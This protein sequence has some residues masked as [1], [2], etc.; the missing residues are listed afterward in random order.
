MTSHHR[1]QLLSCLLME[2]SVRRA[3]HH[4]HIQEPA[5]CANALQPSIP[6]GWFA[7]K[8]SDTQDEQGAV[9]QHDVACMKDLASST[10]QH[11]RPVVH[12]C[13]I[14]S[15]LK[16]QKSSCD[17]GHTTTVTTVHP[18]S[19][20]LLS[21]W[22]LARPDG[23]ELNCQSLGIPV[24]LLLFRRPQCATPS[25]FRPQS[26]TKNELNSSRLWPGCF[27]SCCTLILNTQVTM[28]RTAKQKYSQTCRRWA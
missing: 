8:Q 25:T 6:V 9:V 17:T 15:I 1:W 19:C 10:P 18:L 4:V 7:N 12:M 2:S 5:Q 24:R 13:T 14:Q 27:G 20:C 16:Y 23:L 26:C 11:I 3:L 21:E 28:R 22:A